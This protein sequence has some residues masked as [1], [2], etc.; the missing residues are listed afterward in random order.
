[1]LRPDGQL[2]KVPLAESAVF[3]G[4]MVEHLDREEVI[5][6]VERNFIRPRSAPIEILERTDGEHF[7]TVTFINTRLPDYPDV[8]HII[9][10]SARRPRHGDPHDLQRAQVAPGVRRAVA[11]RRSAV[12]SRPSEDWILKR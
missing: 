6:F 8:L 4:P 9:R 12:A 7:S 1:M 2:A 5:H 11:P 3:I 10:R